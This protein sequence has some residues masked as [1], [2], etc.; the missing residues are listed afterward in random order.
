[1]KKTILFFLTGLVANVILSASIALFTGF[2]FPI[3]VGVAF[4]LSLMVPLPRGVAT[5]VVLEVW[6]NYIVE[7]FWKDNA[8]LRNA[9]D[10]SQYVVAGRIVHIP[11][12]GSLPNVVKNRSTYP[13]TAV[14]RND[15][16][17]VYALDEYSTDPTHIPNIDA[18]HLS[19]NKQDSVLGDH[20]QVLNEIVADDML[21]KWGANA[22]IVKTTG[23]PSA[24]Q[25]GPVG[26]QSGNRLAFHHTDLKKLMIRMNADNVPKQDRYVLIDDNMFEAFYDSLSETQARDFSQYMDA[27]NGIVGRLHGFNILTRSSVLAYDS[28]DAVKALGSVL[29]GTDNLASLA[30]QKNSVAFALGDTKLF[31]NTNDALYYGDVYSALVMAG[32]RVRRNDGLGVYAIVQG[33]PA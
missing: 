25:V 8:F 14:R 3:V 24:T 11:Q 27:A 20:M 12:P 13:A 17:V 7:R 33:T 31:Q 9:Y 29:A 16:D 23:G 1:M 26:G 28:N 32:G 30:W 10:D 22:T 15:T 6:A 4:L 5:G 21:I 2:S 18:I 19:Y